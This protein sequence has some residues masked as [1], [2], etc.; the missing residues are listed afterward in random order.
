M[1]LAVDA[2]DAKEVH[3]FCTLVGFGADAV[4]PSVAYAALYQLNA[5]GKLRV[6]EAA[7][8]DEDVMQNYRNAIGK[9]ML[10]VMAKMGISTLQS[11]KGAQIFEAVG[12]D[13]EVVDRCFV[14]CT[15]RIEGAGFQAIAE[16]I[17]ALHSMAYGDDDENLQD[18]PLLRNPGDYHY[19]HGGERHLN[20]PRAMTEMQFAV[21]H[22]DQA[23]WQR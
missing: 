14:G 22:M 7:L 18:A 1:A 4:C 19:R 15:T 17:Q 8:T 9:G 16:D 20:D 3:D 13:S 2:G 12:L 21:R 11:Y 5:D 23:A 10:K 6:D